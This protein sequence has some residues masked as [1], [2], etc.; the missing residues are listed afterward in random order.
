[1]SKRQKERSAGSGVRPSKVED[2]AEAE[3]WLDEKTFVRGQEKLKYR[4]RCN[5]GLYRLCLPTDA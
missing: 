2:A 1:M 3:Q 5:D 4:E